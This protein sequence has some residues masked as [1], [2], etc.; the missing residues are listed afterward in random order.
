MYR[1]K[2]ASHHR[3][4]D[5]WCIYPSYDYTHGQSDSIEG[6]TH[7]ICT[8]EFENHRPLYD[9]F[10]NALR[11]PP[12]AADRIRAA[13]PHVH[14]DEQAEAAAARAGE[15]RRRLGRPADAHDPRPAPPRL[16]ARGDAGVL[17]ADRRG[18]VQQHDRHGLA[19]RRDSRRPQRAG[20]AGDGRAAAAEGRDHELSGRRGRRARSGQPSAESR[21]WAR[22]P[23]RSRASCTSR[24][25]TSWK[26]RRRSSSG[27]RPAAKCGCGTRTSSRAPT[28]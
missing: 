18:E 21:R 26:T 15:A 9:W 28:W 6:I 13:Q 5:Q 16:H 1:I 2:H 12:P 17:R 3:S 4:G 19:R 11:H 8:L 20:P 7:S 14:G 25:T 22:G 10:C 27:S 24:P 23:C